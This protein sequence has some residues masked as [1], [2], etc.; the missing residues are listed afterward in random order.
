MTDVVMPRLSDSMVEGTIV[1]WLVG[2]GAEVRSGQEIVEIE[3]DKATMP[4]EADAGGYLFIAEPEGSTHPVG[5]VIATIGADP[6]HLTDSATTGNGTIVADRVPD[7]PS[8]PAVSGHAELSRPSASPVARRLAAELSLDLST[9]L[10]TGP[11][12]R[13]VKSDV[14]AAEHGRADAPAADLRE[15]SETRP[16]VEPSTDRAAKG[17]IT[18]IELDRRATVVAR[19]MSEAK[20]TAPEFTVQ[21]T[22]DMTDALALRT[23]IADAGVK[24][25]VNDLV[26]KA[27]AQALT[28]HPGVNAAYRDG[29]IDRYA[30]VNVGIAVASPGSL[31]A[32]T[33]FDADLKS[34]ST[35][36]GQTR[37]LVTA[38]ADGTITAAQLSGATFTVSNLGMYG[39]DSFEAVLNPPQAGIMAVGSIKRLPDWNSAGEIVAR[40]KLAL[41]L[42]CDHRVIYGADAADFLNTVRERLQTPLLLVA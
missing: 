19:R 1:S 40:E 8:G 14:R 36:A 33:V 23:R 15:P 37:A 42:T 10:G 22:V 5:T 2:D 25:S 41:T 31:L 20:A 7:T 34:L 38:A 39:V 13:I 6:V 27:A 21:I 18:R 9:I 16:A 12:G 11:H 30:R 32:A 29:G 4:Y 3:T 24:V 28:L 26:V 35:I 17:E